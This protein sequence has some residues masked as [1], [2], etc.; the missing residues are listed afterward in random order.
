MD[1]EQLKRF[2]EAVEEKKRDSKEASE[3]DGQAYAGGSPVEGDQ[4]ELAEQGPQDV[5]DERKKNSRKG[6]VTADKWNQ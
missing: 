6:K 1:E 2:G 5:F 3:Q 4:S